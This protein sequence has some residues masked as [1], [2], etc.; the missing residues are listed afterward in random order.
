[1]DKNML[2]LYAIYGT[3]CSYTIL[4]VFSGYPSV[5]FIKYL[6]EKRESMCPSNRFCRTSAR[7][8]F[9]LNY[10][11]RARYKGKRNFSSKSRESKDLRFSRKFCGE[12]TIDVRSE[13][14]SWI[15]QNSQIIKIM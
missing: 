1:M 15:E 4:R 14:N 12:T 2:I 13:I 11:D 10:S 8:L 5:V 9:F 7:T 3:L 6:M